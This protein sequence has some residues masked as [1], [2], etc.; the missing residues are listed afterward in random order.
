MFQYWIFQEEQRGT[1]T[2]AASHSG[3]GPDSLQHNSYSPHLILT[4]ST[5]K[6]EGG[7]CVALKHL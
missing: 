1:I 5:L 7:V 2:Y 4:K 6:M 3:K